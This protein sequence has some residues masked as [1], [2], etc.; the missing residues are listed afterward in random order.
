MLELLPVIE[1]GGAADWAPTSDAGRWIALSGDTSDQ[2]IARVVASIAAYS[3]KIGIRETLA[4]TTTAI[5][6]TPAFVV[7]GGLMFRLGDFEAAPGC[8]CG[9]EGWR[10]WEAVGRNGQSPWLG[11]DPMAWID[12]TG[13]RAVFWDDED[14]RSVDVGYDE[15]DAQWK[16]SWD[17]P[18]RPFDADHEGAA[19]LLARLLD[20]LDGAYER[21]GI[22]RA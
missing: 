20:E 8:C 13:E 16:Y 14:G 12:C 21:C 4:E 11:H 7:G 3:R 6:D 5:A 1:N 2:D 10:E 17:G 15:I 22:R 18:R 19:M 9:L